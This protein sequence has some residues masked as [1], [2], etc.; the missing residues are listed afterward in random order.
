M[1]LIYTQPHLSLIWHRDL[2]SHR[3][4]I[5]SSLLSTDRAVVLEAP[6]VVKR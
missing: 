6:R 4:Q 3:V 1:R 5:K 2:G